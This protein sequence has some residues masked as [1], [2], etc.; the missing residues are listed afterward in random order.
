MEE[1]GYDYQSKEF[2]RNL[3]Y[4]RWFVIQCD[5]YVGLLRILENG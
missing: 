1:K 4:G 2:N 5:K 3:K